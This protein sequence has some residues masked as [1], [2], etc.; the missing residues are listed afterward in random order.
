M[1]T[2]EEAGNPELAFE[3]LIN[4]GIQKEDKI[5]DVG[6]NFGTLVNL[7]VKDDY[8]NV[9]GI[10]VNEEAINKGKNAYPHI[11]DK[12]LSY[13]G[14]RL[15]FNENTFEVVTMFDVIEHIP[16]ISRFLNEEVL[17]VLKPGGLLAFQTPNKWLNIVWEAF[18]RRSIHDALYNDHCSLQTLRSLKKLLEK[19]GYMDIVVEK[20]NIYTDINLAKVKS[21]IGFLGPI[22]LKSSVLLPLRSFPNF[23][24]HAEKQEIVS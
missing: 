15:P 8:D 5:L 2:L 12:L 14:N 6:T 1:T 9:L 4:L 19:S 22:V 7:L 11:A 3:Y 20:N 23:Y 10:D 18:R 24:G 13:N 17:R 16:D 21:V